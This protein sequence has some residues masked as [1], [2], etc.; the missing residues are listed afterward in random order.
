MAFSCMHPRGPA[1][2]ETRSTGAL[3]VHGARHEFLSLICKNICN[4]V[5]SSLGFIQP[6][7]VP[8]I[9]LGCS[10]DVLQ[11]VTSLTLGSSLV[12]LPSAGT[13][14]PLTTH[15]VP[16]VQG[17]HLQMLPRSAASLHC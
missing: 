13:P 9:D 3:S 15:T 12:T 10:F 4:L 7:S 6:H 1:A 11:I 14:H 5:Q 16:I 2:S 8:S 17:Q